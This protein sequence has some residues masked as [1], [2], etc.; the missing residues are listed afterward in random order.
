MPDV[1]YADWLSGL[2]TAVVATTQ[3]A[4]GRN[5]RTTS[6]SSTSGS[7]ALDRSTGPSTGAGWRIRSANSDSST[8]SSSESL[9][10]AMEVQPAAAAEEPNQG[11]GM[12]IFLLLL[13]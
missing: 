4:H 6:T 1:Q 5:S 9:V 12:S 13:I 8:S 7:A 10:D 2:E 3:T 11:N